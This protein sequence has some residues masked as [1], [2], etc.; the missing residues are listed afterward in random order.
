MQLIFQD[1]PQMLTSKLAYRLSTLN[2]S[3][4]TVDSSSSSAKSIDAINDSCYQYIAKWILSYNKK[5][6]RDTQYLALSYLKI[7]RKN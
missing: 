3:T 5:I 2:S 7:I 1:T 6:N 4:D